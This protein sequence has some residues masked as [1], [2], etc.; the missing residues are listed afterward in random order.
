MVGSQ[1]DLTLDLGSLADLFLSFCSDMIST[2]KLKFSN[3][4]CS[5]GLSFPKSL[6]LFCTLFK[7]IILA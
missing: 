6:P 5:D 4:P 2:L 3:I 7:L 1:Q